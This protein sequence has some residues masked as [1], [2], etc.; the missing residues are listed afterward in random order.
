VSALVDRDPAAHVALDDPLGVA[1]LLRSLR[2]AG[3]QDQ[4]TALVGRLPTAGTVELFLEQQG[5]ADQF[6]FGREAHGSPSASWGWE[7]LDTVCSSAERQANRRSARRLSVRD[8]L[9]DTPERRPAGRAAW[10]NDVSWDQ[11]A[12]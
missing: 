5:R 12:Q 3:A 4:A 1:V 2:Q 9:P 7:D 11:S 6:R 8:R 10:G